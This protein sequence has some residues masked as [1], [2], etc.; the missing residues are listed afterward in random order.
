MRP[1]MDSAH[2]DSEFTGKYEEAGRIGGW[3]IDRFYARVRALVLP[4]VSAGDTVL[5]VGCGAG[6]SSQRLLDWLPLGTSYL[7]SDVGESLLQKARARNPSASF[8]RQSVYDL[9]LTDKSVDV[10]VM[11]EVL[12]HLEHPARA[13]SEL[14]RV[15][16]KAVILSTPREPLWRMLNMAR[17]KYLLDLGNTPGHVQHWS[18]RALVE[19]TTPYFGLIG[20]FN[21]I[22][23]TVLSLA[24][25]T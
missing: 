9:A 15:A 14:A 23:W 21:P 17:G 12:E 25:R 10:I 11:L 7:G 19:M 18:S 6:Y 4:H 24:P 3:L 22:P 16:R 5:E 1:D 13:L 2:D 8:V 20:R